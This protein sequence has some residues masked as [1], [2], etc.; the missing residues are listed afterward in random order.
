MSGIRVKSLWTMAAV[1]VVAG[2]VALGAFEVLHHD[3]SPDPRSMSVIVQAREMAAAVAL[4]RQA[5]GEVTHELAI[6]NSVGARLTP[7]QVRSVRLSGN[8]R[9]F[10]DRKVRTAGSNQDF[11]PYIIGAS[12]LHAEGITGAGVTVAVLDTGVWQNLQ[13]SLLQGYDATTN[14]LGLTSVTDGSGHGSHVASLIANNEVG[15]SGYYNGVAPG[16]TLII[17]RAFDSNGRG[18]Y[19]DVIRGINWIVANKATYNIRVLNC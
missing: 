6:I 4:V 15:T 2:V 13:N 8:A 11:A 12:Q 1:L 10:A 18:S 9:I 5:G 14:T 7:G 16:A 19:A 17:V 3:R